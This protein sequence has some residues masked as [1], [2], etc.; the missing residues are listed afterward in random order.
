MDLADI[1]Y[2]QR[3]FR[4]ERRD[5]TIIELRVIDTYWSD[6][7][8]HTTFGARLE[9]VRIDDVSVKAAYDRYLAISS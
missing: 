5:P 7:C 6:H 4:G 9:D 3:Y 1:Q 2:C 8:C